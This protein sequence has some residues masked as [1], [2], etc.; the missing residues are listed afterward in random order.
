MATNLYFT[1]GRS[2][3][4]ELYEDLIIESLKIYGQDK[5]YIAKAIVQQLIYLM[6]LMYF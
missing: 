1:Q 2:S 5:S 6:L 4:K 3:E